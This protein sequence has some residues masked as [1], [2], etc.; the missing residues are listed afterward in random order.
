L[1]AV[2]LELGTVFLYLVVV[3]DDRLDVI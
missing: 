1:V 2:A 3:V